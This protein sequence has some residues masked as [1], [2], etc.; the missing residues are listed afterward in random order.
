MYRWNGAPPAS[1]GAPFEP[2]LS[3]RF[4]VRQG[5]SLL[6]E[7]TREVAFREADQARGEVRRPVRVVPR[8]DVK[9]DRDTLLVATGAP[10]AQRFVV[11]LANA[12]IDSAVGRVRLE[13]PPGWAAVP[14]QPFVLP[15][16]AARE[17]F[18]FDVRPPA[19]LAAGRYA[20]RAVAEAGGERFDEG[21]H[22][23]DHPHVRPRGYRRAAVV[24]IVAAPVALPRLTR[25]GYIRGAAD[26]SPEALASIGVPIELLDAGALER[27]DLSRY[28]AIVVGPRA[29]ETDPALVEHSARLLAYA[30]AGGLV[31]VQYQ[32][33]QFVRG[34]FAPLPLTIAT[35][36]GR[37][38][39]ETAPV[40]VIAPGHP[41]VTVPNVLG[42]DDWAGWV[43][44]RGL[45]F[46]ERWDPGYVA[47]LESADPGSAPLRGGVLVAPL[48]RGT[49]VYT[50]IAF[51]RQLPAGVPGA[52]RL[53][54]NLLALPRGAT[55]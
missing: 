40:R 54:A 48:G 33:Y 17:A 42:A 23:V 22:V 46:A 52:F 51:F 12:G 53:F 2:P 47:V 9:V 34:R 6:F 5:D 10:R 44:E 31:I 19:G 21:V 7:A 37:V 28:D 24:S 35:P 49:Y 39:D 45:Y 16:G 30:R 41:A 20:L 27:G 43:Q 36:H 18:A 14:A 13:L 29:Y 1:L 32:Q 25:V 8:I 50:G 15:P 38:A 11:T 4:E 55:P 3:V 26:R